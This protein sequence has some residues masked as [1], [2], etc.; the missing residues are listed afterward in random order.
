MNKAV[1]KAGNAL[2]YVNRKPANLPKGV[3]VVVQTPSS[4]E[5]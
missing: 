5:S 4:P 2:V 1:L 3:V